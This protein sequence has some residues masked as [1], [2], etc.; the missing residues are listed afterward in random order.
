[1]GTTTDKLNAVLDSKEAIRQ[2]IEYRGVDIPMDT[3]LAEYADKIGEI[4]TGG[5][6]TDEQA[7]VFIGE[8]ADGKR[9]IAKAVRS[10]YETITN[11][12]SGISEYSTFEEM[13]NKI[14]DIPITVPMGN[15]MEQNGGVL[16]FYDVYN[17]ALKAWNTFGGRGFKGCCAFELDKWD[18]DSDHTITLSGAS[19]YYTSDKGELI[20][21]DTE[22][23]FKDIDQPN[24]NR[25]VVY[26]FDI[27]EGDKYQVPKSLPA[28]SCLGLWC[29]K[30][31]P[32][33][34]F[35]AD[36]TQINSINVYDGEL[37]VRDAND[38]KF[39][40][41]ANN[42]KVRLLHIKN[43]KNGS[44]IFYSNSALREISLP[45]LTTC[46]IK[47]SFIG[48]CK[49]ATNIKMPSLKT[50][51][52]TNYTSFFSSMTQTLESVDMSSL[53]IFTRT[54]TTN[55][56]LSVITLN[57]FALPKAHNI[58]SI[59][60]GNAKVSNIYLGDGIK[61]GVAGDIRVASQTNT[62]LTTLTVANGFKANLNLT[63]CNGLER[64]VLLGIINNLA[65]LKGTEY[66]DN[67]QLTLGSTLY[68]KL[69]AD[70]IKIG[71]D[72]GWKVTG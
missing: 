41:I 36:F 32:L 64:D 40:S 1:M 6:L 5:T 10:K 42:Q 14:A 68:N 19:A 11:E 27:E 20:T 62:Y 3:T 60:T 56:I 49:A 71:T 63:G 48:D 28:T 17:E 67:L 53:E 8:C 43:I 9:K 54:D 61:D 34:N 7:L 59:I 69:T 22:Y 66:E 37:E 45:N 46:D 50:L 33:M 47:S 38:F 31:T 12:E 65:D 2:A 4:P 72:K 52:F 16:P 30:G 44:N 13:S 29:I 51:K 55:A 25:F 21:A 70:D 58:A 26:F 24:T 18:Y 15:A 39:A 23:Q 57:E 35:S